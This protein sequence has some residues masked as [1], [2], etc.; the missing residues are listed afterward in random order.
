MVGASVSTRA[1]EHER[2]KRLIEAGVNVLVI[3]SSQVETY[4]RI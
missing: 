3:D 4:S 1:G 2:V